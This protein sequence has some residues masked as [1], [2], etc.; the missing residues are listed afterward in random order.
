MVSRKTASPELLSRESAAHRL[1][2]VYIVRCSD[3]TLYTGI[4]TD[5]ARRVREHN[6]G[7]AG[8]KYTRTRRPVMLVYHE[9]A[10]SRAEAVRRE[11]LLKVVP[12][13]VKETL[14]YL[15]KQI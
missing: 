6:E 9:L 10:T 15:S 7:K 3:S 5:L 11:V 2:Y 13:G 1:W 8:A 4:T 14:L 12:R